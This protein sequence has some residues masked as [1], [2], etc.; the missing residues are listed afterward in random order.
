MTLAFAK[1]LEVS[2]GDVIGAKAA[3]PEQ[4]RPSTDSRAIGPGETFVCLRG[5]RFDGHAYAA[6]AAGRG[7]VAIVADDVTGIGA[8]SVPIVRVPDAKAAYLAG[9]AASRKAFAGTVV[10]ITGSTGKTTTKEFAAQIIGSKR[11]VLATPQN[12]NN[13]L[14]VAKVCYRMDERSDVAVLEFGARHPGEIAQLV[15]IAKPD[16]GILTNIGEAHLEFFRGQEELAR[17]KFAL[18]GGGAKPV[19]SAGDVWSRM[20]AA[21]AGASAQ[22]MWVRLVG[23]PIMAG[24]MLEAGVPSD[25]QVPVTLGASHAFAGWHLFGEHHLRDALAAA[26]AAILAGLSFEDAL[27][28]LGDLRLP[29]GRFETH[30]ASSGATIIYDAYNASP[31]SMRQA[32]ASFAAI[33]ANRHVAVLGSMAEL[34]PDARRHHE[35]VGAAAAHMGADLI[36]AGGD[37]A[38]AIA[39]GAR[40]AGAAPDRVLIYPDNASALESLRRTITAGD[41]VLLKGSRVQHLEEILAGLLGSGALA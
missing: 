20:L 30:R 25:G 2:G 21:E 33:P 4:F 41:C 19:L 36:Y 40:D 5:E 34:G 26:G 27:G 10:A 35:A 1:F 38:D 23:D 17:T 15:G 3:L 37:F 11:R 6:Q 28:V 22:V 12:E 13:E 8:A 31:S 14:G 9:A 29:A 24:I 32:L 39:K 18:F 16:I 7:A